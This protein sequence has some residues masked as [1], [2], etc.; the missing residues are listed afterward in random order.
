VKNYFDI[1]CI[2]RIICI[3][4]F[5][6]FVY[7]VQKKMISGVKVV[8]QRVHLSRYLLITNNIHVRFP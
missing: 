7:S 4:Y 8:R 1:I 5:Q 2:I 6:Y 3:I